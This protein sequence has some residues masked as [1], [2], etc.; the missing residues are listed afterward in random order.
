MAKLFLIGLGGDARGLQMFV[1]WYVYAWPVPVLLP[2]LLAL[3]R[4]AALLAFC[5]YVAVGAVIVAAWS[6]ASLALGRA[7]NTPWQNVWGYLLFLGMQAWLPLLVI[8][9]TGSR[10]LRSVAPIVL[11]GL[12]LFS[13]GTLLLTNILTFL[14]DFAVLRDALLVVGAHE[15]WVLWFMLAALPIGYLCWSAVRWLSIAF[16]NRAFSDTQLLVDSWWLIAVFFVT[17]SLATDLGWGGLAGLLGFV[18]YRATVALGTLLWPADRSSAGG[19]RL[20]LLRVFGFQ[21]RTERLFDIIAQRWRL[22]GN[23]RLIGARDLAMR[24]IDPS[25]VVGFIGGRL[26]RQFVRDGADLEQRLS[27]LEETPDPD[28]RFQIDKFFCHDNTWR[29]TLQALLARSDVVLMDL[30]GFSASNQGCRFELGQLVVSGLLPRTVLAVD[31]TTDVILLE[32]TLRDEALQLPARGTSLQL[33]IER[34]Q[35][36]STADLAR[37]RTRLLAL[38]AQ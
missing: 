1:V 4:R 6:I 25:D 24:T 14:L 8:L 19:R 31:D 18:V 5:G 10:R 13:F 22:I 23:V 20:L 17:T 11:A 38:V 2:T 30:R 37:V 32:A 35:P 28:G 27:R 15:L 26:R 3:P 36:S 16:E 29:P 12:L 21:R 33:N 9:A 34:I 7:A